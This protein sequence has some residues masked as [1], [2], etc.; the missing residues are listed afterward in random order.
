MF[1]NLFMLPSYKTCRMLYASTTHPIDGGKHRDWVSIPSGGKYTVLD[2]DGCG[3]VAS[4][5]FTISSRDRYVLR[6]TILNIYWDG[7]SKPSVDT[8]IGDFVGVGF[9]EYKHHNSLLTGE[10]SGGYYS[11]IPM[12]FSKSCRVEFI[13]RGFEPIRSLYVMLGYYLFDEY[14]GC[15]VRFHAKW[16]RENPTEEGKPYTIL[17]AEGSGFYIGTRLDMSPINKSHGFTYLEGNFEFIVDGCRDLSY[18]STGTE[19]YF[20]SGWY[21]IHGVYAAAT[22]GLLIKDEHRYRT[23]C[24]RYHVFDPIPFRRS[25]TVRVHH[26]EYDEVPTDYSSVAYWYQCEPHRD[27]GKLCVEEDR[28]PREEF[29]DMMKAVYGKPSIEYEHVKGLEEVL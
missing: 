18:G 13:N 7:E 6:N 20:L 3:Y 28:I 22:H 8:P 10:T 26:G 5:W 11:F 9:G 4:I 27:F 15:D 29:T 24:Y 16:R 21:F 1:L 19:D 2:V 25:I 23:S 14:H 12:P 17:E